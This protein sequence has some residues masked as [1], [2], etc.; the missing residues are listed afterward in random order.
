MTRDRDFMTTALRLAQRGLGYVWPNPAVGCVIV[1]SP[2]NGGRVLGRGW[3]QPSGRPHAETVALDQARVRFGTDALVGAHVYVTLEPCSHT[4]KTSPCAKALSAAKVG[5]VIVACEDPDPRVS[6]AGIAHLREA[7]VQVETGLCLTEA[8]TVNAGFLMRVRAGRPLVSL[9]TATTSDG[10][11]ATRTGAS[12]WITGH[13]ARAHAHLMRATH[14]AIAVGAGTVAIDDPTLTCRLPGMSDRSPLRVVF[15]S[16]LRTQ[17]DAQ[18]V[19]TACNVPT[20]LIACEGVNADRKTNFE[21]AGVRVWTVAEDSGRIDLQAALSVLGDE[22]ITRLMVEGG[23]Q[24]STA[25]LR[26]GLVDQI[27]WFRAPSLIGGDGMPP[28]G[29]LGVGDMSEMPAFRSI[30]RKQVGNDMLDIFV[31]VP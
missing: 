19:T 6:G 1:A 7:G 23:A 24:I 25:L 27:L 20:C 13:A 21:D 26:A 29:D 17:T 10:R 18:L 3:T 31:R 15:D 30:E 16:Q 22:G 9:K 5:R 28:F 11:I 8:E 12:Q 2:E 4:G 14:D